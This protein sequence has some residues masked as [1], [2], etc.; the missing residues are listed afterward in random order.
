MGGESEYSTAEDLNVML[1]VRCLAGTSR[2]E[3]ERGLVIA[4]QFFFPSEQKLEM[5]S[6][7]ECVVLLL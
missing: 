1:N 4:E 6:P 5:P 2:M 7:L 3:R